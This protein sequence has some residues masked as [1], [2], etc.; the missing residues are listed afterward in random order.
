MVK[1]PDRWEFIY[2]K[3]IQVGRLNVSKLAEHVWEEL[4]KKFYG[5]T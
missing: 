1:P 2:L 3:N 4:N 5:K